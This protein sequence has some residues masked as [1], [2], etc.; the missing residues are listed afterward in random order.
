MAEDKYQKDKLREYIEKTK[1]ITIN[2]HF[3]LRMSN[4]LLDK[5]TSGTYK[6]G[7]NNLVNYTNQIQKLK[8]IY[9]ANAKPIFYTYIVPDDQFVELLNYPYKTRKGGGKPVPSYDIDG[10]NSAFGQSQNIF[11]YA[12]DKKP[13]ISQIVNGIH[14]Y[15]H[16]VHSQFFKKD[17]L[18]SEGFAEALPLYTLGYESKFIEHRNFLKSLKLNQIYSP[19]Q[20]LDMQDN[21]TFYGKAVEPHKSCSFALSYVSSYLFVRGCIETVASKYK[22]D[23]VQATQKF[24][25]V[26]RS[27]QCSHGWLIYD[28]ADFL[29]I[30]RNELLNTKKLQNKVLSEIIQDGLNSLLL[31]KTT[32]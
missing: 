26:V 10:F 14:E 12:F 3:R 16:L 4:E 27:S 18:I 8:L 1:I 2:D 6:D 5:Y 31:Q 29:G 13:T 17:R 21:G 30:P 22:L 32:I 9:P 7:I 19:K 23:R 20:L 11:E 28:L 15:A 24:L 25:E